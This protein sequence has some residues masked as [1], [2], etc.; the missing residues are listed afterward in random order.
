MKKENTF[1][2]IHILCHNT[3]RN[4]YKPE[5]KS[6]YRALLMSG[7]QEITSVIWRTTSSLRRNFPSKRGARSNAS[8]WKKSRDKIF[9]FPSES[10]EIDEVSNL[11]LGPGSSLTLRV[12]DLVRRGLPSGWSP[13][14]SVA[15]M[16]NVGFATRLNRFVSF[17]PPPRKQNWSNNDED[18]DSSG[19]LAGEGW[20]KDIATLESL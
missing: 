20:R 1:D 2:A 13:F 19:V 18:V 6:L 8:I 4:P 11:D 7:N 3:N 12:I 5:V 17:I 15:G 16:A 10:S 9:M 14:E